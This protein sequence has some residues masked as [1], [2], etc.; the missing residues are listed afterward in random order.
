MR[1]ILN[2]TCVLRS[3]EMWE[4][5]TERRT[6]MDSQLGKCDKLVMVSLGG[7][8]IHAVAEVGSFRQIDMLGAA[9]VMTET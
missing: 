6:E 2:L 3:E 8:E 5:L 7:G 4:P 9:K 1:Y